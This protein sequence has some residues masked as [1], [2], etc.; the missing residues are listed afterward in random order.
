MVNATESPTTGVANGSTF[1]AMPTA[2]AVGFS[3]SGSSVVLTI[4]RNGTGHACR[5]N[6]TPART[7]QSMRVPNERAR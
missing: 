4:H 3:V 6:N 2:L 5:R 7:R 1:S